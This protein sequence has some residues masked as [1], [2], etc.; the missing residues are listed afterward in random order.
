MFTKMLALIIALLHQKSVQVYPY[1]DDMLVVAQSRAKMVYAI[2][3]TILI[4]QQA[5]FLI[6]LKKSHLN[7]T[8]QIHFLGMNLHSDTA[9]AFLP[10]QKALDL[11]KCAQLM[12]PVGAYRPARL[13]L[14]LLGLM[15][16]ALMTVPHARLYMRPVQVYFNAHWNRQTQGLDH[17]IMTPLRLNQS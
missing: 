6:N 3:T 17:K 12:F 14:R 13:Y 10:M 2:Q 11:Q 9:L 7:M 4:L 16:A 1:L 8:Q 15:A 5:G